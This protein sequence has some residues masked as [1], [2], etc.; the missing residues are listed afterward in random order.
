M[1]AKNGIDLINIVQRDAVDNLIH[2]QTFTILRHNHSGN[3]N[4]FSQ[5]NLAKVFGQ[6]FNHA[7]KGPKLLFTP[8]AV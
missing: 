6:G 5:K 7:V 3:A 1:I 4:I 8:M 2:K